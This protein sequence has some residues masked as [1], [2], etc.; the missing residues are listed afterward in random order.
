MVLGGGGG[1]AHTAR[2]GAHKNTMVNVHAPFVS[3]P[4]PVNNNIV[5]LSS[6]EY[7]II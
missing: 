1:G 7:N 4:G 5:L 2:K 6:H 3:L